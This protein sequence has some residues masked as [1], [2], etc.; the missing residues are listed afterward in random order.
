[1]RSIRRRWS[2]F[3]SSTTT[4][5]SS[6][7]LASNAVNAVAAPAKQHAARSSGMATAATPLAPAPTIAVQRSSVDG[8]PPTNGAR[9]SN[10]AH[11]GAHFWVTLNDPQVY[12][13]PCLPPFNLVNRV[14]TLSSHLCRVPAQNGTQF[15]ACPS[16]GEC[17]WEP[18]VGNFVYVQLSSP[19]VFRPNLRLS[20]L[21]YHPVNLGNG[22]NSA[23][24][25]EAV[26]L[27]TITR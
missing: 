2:V 24:I 3:K 16:T 19:L 25:P 5:S 12:F 17:S 18:P 20:S 21:V 14:L 22:G 11:W 10:D 1:M 9:T 15:F 13:L 8:L 6:S 7:T 23:T 4:T 27:T 26:Y